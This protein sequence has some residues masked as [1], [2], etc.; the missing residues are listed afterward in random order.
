MADGNARGGVSDGRENHVTDAAG[1]LATIASGGHEITLGMLEAG[2]RPKLLSFTRALPTHDL[3]FLPDDITDEHVVDAWIAAATAGATPTVIAE[4]DGAIVGYSSVSV[5]EEQWTK[6]VAELR[7]V[8]A[9]SSR[10][11]GLGRRLVAEAFRI[12]VDLGVEKMVARMTVD[13]NGALRLFQGMGFQSEATLR[14]H[15]RD[16]EGE[17]H[18]LI[19]LGHLTALFLETL[20]LTRDETGYHATVPPPLDPDEL[21]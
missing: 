16:R 14:D 21:D 15:V 13:Q 10:G 1:P 11:H 20:G 17:L 9:E 12:G 3:L 6:H 2:D 4:A 19:V 8:V 7:L 5:S 18:D